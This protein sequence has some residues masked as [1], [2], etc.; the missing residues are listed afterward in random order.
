M[1]LQSETQQFNQLESMLAFIKT[2]MSLKKSLATIN[3]EDHLDS[4]LEEDSDGSKLKDTLTQVLANQ[5]SEMLVFEGLELI[6]A[7]ENKALK[8]LRILHGLLR[9]RSD[10]SKQDQA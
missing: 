2:T 7:L 9:Q 10:L 6:L 1:N 4:L 3:L 8:V 5:G